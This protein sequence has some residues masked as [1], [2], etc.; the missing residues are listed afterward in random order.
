MVNFRHVYFHVLQWGGK[1]AIATSVFVMLD[2]PLP[3]VPVR[4][5]KHP[6]SILQP[7]LL[8]RSTLLLLLMLLLLLLPPLPLEPGAVAAAADCSLQRRAA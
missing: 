8:L 7:Q 3:P 1:S 5:V 2:V 4:S 6:L